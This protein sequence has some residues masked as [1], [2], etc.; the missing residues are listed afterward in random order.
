M[1]NVSSRRW[2]SVDIVDLRVPREVRASGLA[3]AQAPDQEAI[4][5]TSRI[6]EGPPRSVF[7]EDTTEE[8]YRQISDRG[9]WLHL[10]KL[11][12]WGRQLPAFASEVLRDLSS[13]NP[14]W[15]LA[16]GDRDEFPTWMESRFGEAPVENEE[17]F[18]NLSDDAILARLLTLTPLDRHDD[19]RRWQKVI[20]QNPSRAS[21][22][23]S[24][25]AV[26]QQWPGDLWDL[27]LQGFSSSKVSS[28]EWPRFIGALLGAPHS[29]FEKSTRQIAWLLHEVSSSLGAEADDQFWK[30]W[31]RIQP[32]AFQDEG[33]DLAQDAVTRAINVP[34]GLL[35]QAL[36]DRL[37]A[38][39]PRS[40]AETSTPIWARL[41][42]IAGGTSRA[43]TYARVVLASRLAWIHTLSP[44]WTESHLL[45]RFDWAHS[46]EA[47]AVWQ[48]YLWQ[49]RV[50]PELWKAI[51]GDF[52]A[53]LREK[54][55]LR[56]F[57]E[58]I[59]TLFGYVCIDLPDW[60]SADEVQDALRQM[61]D[62]GLAAV[63]RV[64]FRRLQGAGDKGEAMW[65]TLIGPWLDL[66]WPKN[67]DMVHPSS[68]FNLAM[69]ATY[70]GDVFESAVNLVLPFLTGSEDYGLA[71]DRLRETEYP[72]RCP[73]SVLRLLDIV[74]TSYAWPDQNLRALLS[75]I[76]EVQPVLVHDSKFRRLDEYLLR[77]DI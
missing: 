48:G 66:N 67:R 30:V 25:I 14:A 31:D 55:K 57:E 27:A 17:E 38:G 19:L 51:K 3:L 76:Q 28:S 65:R 71:V 68:A 54:H 16:G 8:M 36:L 52:L 41:T 61:D 46:D 12:S 50:T 9:V 60:L 37:A 6:I 1:P 73:V 24:M 11:Q 34:A 23:L 56:A 69:A 18:L 70:A 58:E 64:I 72:E 45:T 20:S 44:D 40:P 74:D 75:R 4:L 62:K 35:T 22:L 26:A 15:S 42:V 49:A 39:R 63:A 29:F 43:H 13:K 21:Q 10:V 33:G 7:R 5:L 59:S 2:W 53:A 32:F 47:V 77:H